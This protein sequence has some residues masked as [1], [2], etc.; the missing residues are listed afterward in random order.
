MVKVSHG[1]EK[2][3]DF[4]L[5]KIME[6]LQGVKNFIKNQLFFTNFHLKFNFL[7]IIKMCGMTE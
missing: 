4:S 7:L 3:N 5:D 2:S 1:L 6:K